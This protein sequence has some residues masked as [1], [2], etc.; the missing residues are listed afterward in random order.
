MYLNGS[1]GGGGGADHVTIRNNIFHDTHRGWG[2]QFYPGALSDIHVLNNTFAFCNESKSYTCIV[3]DASISSSTIKNNIF[4]NP[5]GGKTIEAAGFSGS[6]TL[7]HN[8]TSGNAMHDLG[9]ILSGMT[10]VGNLLSTNPLLVGPPGDFHLSSG[11]P[12]INAGE[13]LTAVPNDYEGRSR[14][15]GGAYDIGAYERP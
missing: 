7:G 12:A 9:S 3:L 11:S 6:I 4:Y 13:T 10:L 15:Q 2:V 5:A 1:T 14:P 8:L